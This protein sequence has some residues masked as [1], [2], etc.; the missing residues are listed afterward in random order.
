MTKL[1]SVTPAGVTTQGVGPGPG[2]GRG[3]E[4]S[5]SW[6]GMS[7]AVGLPLAI[8]AICLVFTL[9]EP[10]FFTVENFQNVGRQSSSLI[11]LAVAL[12]LVVIS[13]GLDL[14]IGSTMGLAS[15][16][17]AAA[18]GIVGT[19]AGYAAGI[20][21]GLVVGLVNGIVIAGA[22]VNPFIATIGMLSV[23]R[24]LTYVFSDARSVLDVSDGFDSL[25]TSSVLG[26]PAPLLLVAVICVVLGLIMRY[27]RF[28]THVFAL[29]G[30]ELATW[31]AGVNTRWIKYRLYLITG[32]FAGL[33]GVIL[34]SRVNTGQPTLG[35]GTELEVVAAILI[36]GVSI[37][38]GHGSLV[39][40]ALAALFISILGNGFNLI[41]LQAYWQ[42]VATGAIIVLATLG[43]VYR[44][45]GLGFWGFLRSLFADVS[46][47]PNRRRKAVAS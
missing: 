22:G 29:G 42:Q 40:V 47:S 7:S 20:L 17:A 14:S 32:G 46:T 23:V 35:V 25:A 13:G 16:S 39:K 34:S 44:Q 5:R 19:S 10:A 2:P 4:R 18:S 28:G 21:A 15:I 9:L 33:A 30:S 11:L 1:E 41:G 24:G 27:T 8:V 38:G 43:T 12:G 6:Q 31:K 3:R 26:I 36:A 45:R 37:S